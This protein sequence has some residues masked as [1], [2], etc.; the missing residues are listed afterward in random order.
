MASFGLTLQQERQRRGIS[1]DDVAGCTRVARRYLL[2]LEDESLGTLPGGP[3]NRAYLRAYAAYL[4]L[5]ADSLVREYDL[6]ARAQSD[7]GQLNVEPDAR[8]AMRV[9][10]ERRASQIS[11]RT[12]GSTTALRVGAVIGGVLALLAAVVW[13]AVP[14]FTHRGDLQQLGAHPLPNVV[15]DGSGPSAIEISASPAELSQGA[16][17]P[18][19]AT[20]E[21]VERARPAEPPVEAVRSDSDR[22]ARLSIDSFAV[23]TDVVDRRLV[24]ESHTFAVDTRVAFWTLVAGGRAGDTV[25]HVWIHQGRTVGAVELGVG[26]AHWRTYSWRTLTPGSEGDW[27]V[28][29]RDAEGR[30]LAQYSFRCEPR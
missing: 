13:F 20:G 29:A 17:L 21:A 7:A 11:G 2:A 26:S 18:H 4:G 30:V 6:R 22:G 10:A 9:A 1:L 27:V 3:Y 8:T 19:P 12:G 14:H 5:D 25:R 28:E 15:V 23:G 24:G 16:K